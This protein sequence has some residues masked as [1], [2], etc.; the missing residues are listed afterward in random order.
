[1]RAK[2]IALLSAVAFLTAPVAWGRSLESGK[3]DDVGMSSERLAKIGEVFRA[4]IQDGK[5]PGAV[6][7]IA[8]KGKVAYHE[9][10]GYQ[11][12]STEKTMAKDSIFR[13]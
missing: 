10:F 6:I 11:D 7:M 2:F 5:L 13:I 9:A 3:P 1:M 8:R 4:E 12:K